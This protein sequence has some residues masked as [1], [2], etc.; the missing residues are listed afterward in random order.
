[1]PEFFKGL[2]R[3]KRGVRTGFC[4]PSGGDLTNSVVVNLD[5]DCQRCNTPECHMFKSIYDKDGN[6]VG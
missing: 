5:N 3:R 6:I 2:P 4:E 1:M